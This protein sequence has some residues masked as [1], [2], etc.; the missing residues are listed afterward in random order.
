M[1]CNSLEGEGVG[2]ADDLNCRAYHVKKWQ[3]NARYLT[4]TV[5]RKWEG[6]EWTMTE[7][8]KEEKASTMNEI[9]QCLH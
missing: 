8:T 3:N 6:R 7:S 4:L 5:S 2:N 9:L 1:Y